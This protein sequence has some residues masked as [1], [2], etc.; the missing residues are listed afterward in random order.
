MRRQGEHR[1]ARVFHSHADRA[2]DGPR[3]GGSSIASRMPPTCAGSVSR[4]A[5]LVCR[6]RVAG[7]AER[8]PRAVERPSSL[9]A[10]SPPAR[11]RVRSRAS[12][13][14]RFTAQRGLGEGRGN[15]AFHAVRG[16]RARHPQGN[17]RAERQKMPAFG[18]RVA[19]GCCRAD[20]ERPGQRDGARG[21]E[22]RAQHTVPGGAVW[23]AARHRC[24]ARRSR[25]APVDRPSPQAGAARRRRHAHSIF[26]LTPLGRPLSDL[27]AT[28]SQR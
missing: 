28:A 17:S 11:E 12:G 25:P 21:I 26:T 22:G 9:V 8:L 5:P 1:T 7:A 20:D 3:L 19:T 24:S 27:T 10:C 13:R 4:H 14:A 18:L 6:A 15:Q 23:C 16:G 2:I